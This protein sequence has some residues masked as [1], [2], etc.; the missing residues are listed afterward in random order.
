MPTFDIIVIALALSIDAFAVALA[1]S[2]AGHL[3]TAR[4]A[5]RIAFHFGL[6]QF[7]MPVLGWAA[8]VAVAP[9]IQSTDHWVAFALLA[10]VGGRMIHAAR[11]DDDAPPPDDPSRGASLVMLSTAVSVDALAVGLTLAML[12]V[13]ILLPGAVIGI[14]TATVS[15][16][17][18]FLGTKMHVR[19]GKVAETVGGIVLILI[20]LRVVIS[21][22]FGV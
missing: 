10:F 20:G 7:L 3:R 21:H 19:F 16:V 12:G 15:L 14:V 6:F 1:A 9:L 18:I 2:A 22:L 17:G 13:D 11:R 4:S 5:V 8:G